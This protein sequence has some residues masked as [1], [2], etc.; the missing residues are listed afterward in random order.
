MLDLRNHGQSFHHQDMNY[1]VMVEDVYRLLTHLGISSCRLIGH[2]MGG[3][4]GILLAVE[5]PELI[6]HLLVVD[7]APVT[8][9]HDYRS[10][11]DPILNID[12][13]SIVSR[14][15]VDEKL[16]PDIPDSALRNFLLQSLV[17]DGEHWRWAV[18]WHA[19]SQHI[20][21]LSAFPALVDGWKCDTASLFLRGEDSDY[22]GE[23]E[24]MLIAQHFNNARIETLAN[25]GHWLQVEQ[26]QQFIEASLRFLG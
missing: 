15:V 26:P 14:S 7:I 6:S 23:A 20:G 10:L 13:S 1:G 5:Y 22:I 25:A 2:S 19:I 11:I 8:Y 3:K 12:L 9:S 16:K 18:N 4:T 17:R 21:E 24:A